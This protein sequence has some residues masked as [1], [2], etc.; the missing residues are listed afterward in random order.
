MNTNQQNVFH[1]GRKVAML[2]AVLAIN[3]TSYAAVTLTAPEEVAVLALDQQEIKGSLF[4][5]NKT[6]YKLDP[7]THDIAVRY[8]QIFNHSNGEHDVLKSGVVS[9]RADLADNKTYRL[10]LVNAPKYF[11]DAQKYVKQPTFA[12]LDEQGNVVAQQQSLDNSPKPLLG[13]SNVFNRVLDFRGSKKDQIQKA[14]S[15]YN[16]TPV[17]NVQ[18]TPAPV[19]ATVSTTTSANTVATTVQQ[20]VSQ[21]QVSQAQVNAAMASPNT[22]E[23]LKALWKNT[24][25]QERQQFIQ[26]IIR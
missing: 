9:V 25:E 14:T 13:G 12:V 10:A 11:D 1:I 2:V 23:L 16:N 20:P 17:N 8:E 4:R 6:T 24:T 18:T 5:T 3:S 26:Y 19:P 15:T 7:G 22:L 21:P